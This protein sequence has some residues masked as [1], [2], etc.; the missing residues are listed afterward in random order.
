[1]APRGAILLVMPN[2]LATLQILLGAMAGGYWRES[3]NFS[4]SPSRSLRA[5]H[6]LR[7]GV[8]LAEWAPKVRELV[9]KSR[10]RSCH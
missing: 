5:R 10:D 6:R 7:A 9:S 4:R 1:M 8:R 3:V 2:G